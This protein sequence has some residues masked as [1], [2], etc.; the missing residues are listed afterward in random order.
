MKNYPIEILLFS[1]KPARIMS[2]GHHDRESFIAAARNAGYDS[3]LTEPAQAWFKAVPTGN[4]EV[5]T[6]LVAERSRG[7]FPG[8]YS[9][10]VKEN[11]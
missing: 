2:R 8:T 3:D 4:G 9:E 10:I 7:C 1:S 11:N 6:H 5:R